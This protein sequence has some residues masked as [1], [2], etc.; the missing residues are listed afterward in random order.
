[1]LVL[2]A[3]IDGRGFIAGYVHKTRA[4]VGYFFSYILFD[5]ALMKFHSKNTGI[6]ILNGADNFSFIVLLYVRIISII[7]MHNIHANKNY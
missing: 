4:K 5:F 7:Y 2:S 1:M 3:L 6:K